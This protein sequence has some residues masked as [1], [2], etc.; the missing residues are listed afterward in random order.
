MMHFP[1]TPCLGFHPGLELTGLEVAELD[2]LSGSHHLGP[3]ILPVSLS[4]KGTLRSRV[5]RLVK[6]TGADAFA[7]V[8]A[9]ASLPGQVRLAVL[10]AQDE[11][12]LLPLRRS[13]QDFRGCLHRDG[14]TPTPGEMDASLMDHLAAEDERISASE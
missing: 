7:R 13:V 6:Q 11:V 12:R 8:L 5:I 2:V 14:P 1:G 4:S 10:H 9:D 3:K